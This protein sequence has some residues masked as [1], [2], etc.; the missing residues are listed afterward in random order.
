MVI[1]I[2]ISPGEL[3]DKITILEI[4][5]ASIKDKQKLKIIAEEQM[6]LN[7]EFEKVQKNFPAA[8]GKIKALKKKLYIINKKLWDTENKLRLME[9]KKNFGKEF[10]EAARLVYLYNDSRSRIKNDFNRLLG[11]K[12]S[13]IKSY[14]KY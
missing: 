1:K 5:A 14:A 4:K 13:E 2:R 7:K 3:I 12:L 8:L 6:L 11:S 9:S 10:I